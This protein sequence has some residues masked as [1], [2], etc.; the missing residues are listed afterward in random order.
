MAL[1][2][3]EAAHKWQGCESQKHLNENG[4]LTSLIHTWG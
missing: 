4:S 3:G 1:W 2:E